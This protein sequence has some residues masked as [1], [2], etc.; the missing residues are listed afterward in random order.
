MVRNNV[1][2]RLLI[3]GRPAQEFFHN[4]NT[5]LEGR[6]GSNFEV[7]VI[8]RNPFRIEAVISVDG[9]SVVDGSL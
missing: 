5:F 4:G 3:K 7:E 1:E 2:L 6:E 9:L 8:N